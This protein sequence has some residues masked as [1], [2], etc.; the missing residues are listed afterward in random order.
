MVL[1]GLITN[2][3]IKCPALR[4][5]E[6]QLCTLAYSG[7][8]K[9]HVGD[10]VQVTG[11]PA[12]V[13][14]CMQGVLTIQVESLQILYHS[15]GT[16]MH[17]LGKTGL[18]PM[19]GL[20]IDLS[21]A[22]LVYKITDVKIHILKCNPPKLSIS[23]Q[24]LYNSTGWSFPHLIDHLYIV[25]PSDGIWDY[26]CLAL[27]PTRQ[28]NCIPVPFSFTQIFDTIPGKLCGV[29]IHS[30]TTPPV[31][32]RFADPKAAFA[33][34]ALDSEPDFQSWQGKLLIRSGQANPGGEVVLEDTLKSLGTKYR[35]LDPKDFGAPGIE[36]DRLTIL[37]DEN[38]FI[39][40][41]SWG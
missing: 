7:E 4:T 25:E 27:P 37:L 40:S 32:A 12:Q 5:T 9:I 33:P 26:S 20:P 23:I 10:L 14:I 39:V 30:N 19:P 8:P 24:G 21:R 38:N 36:F 3:G 41:I 13:S 28:T 11:V 6:G 34:Y 18:F 15:A 29:R 22:E 16:T 1:I 2:E 35:I 31:V 17:S